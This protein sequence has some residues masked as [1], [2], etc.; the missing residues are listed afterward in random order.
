[1]GDGSFRGTTT[2]SNGTWASSSSKMRCTQ[3]MQNVALA[4]AFNCTRNAT[5]T[6]H[7]QGPNIRL[8]ITEPM[9][10]WGS[11]DFG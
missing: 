7:C 2:F 8:Q 11:A 9:A 5:G 3:T 4:H 6:H 1:M 10:P